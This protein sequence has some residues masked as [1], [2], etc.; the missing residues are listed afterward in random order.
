[1]RRRTLK[2]ASIAWIAAVAAGLAIAQLT[3]PPPSPA[4]LFPQGALV[5]AEARDL[6]Q[7]LQWWSGSEVKSNWMQTTNYT[8]F[9]N[10][11]LYQRLD[12]RLAEF[13]KG[14][15]AFTL[16]NLTEIAG[17]SSALALYD[18]GE[19][20]A[21][22]VTRV[23]FAEATASELWASRAHLR[24]KK[25]G[26]QYYYVEPDEGK[27]A[28][29]FAK[30]YLVI[31]SEEALLQDLLKAI[32]NPAAE[33]RLTQSDK[34]QQLA[35]G[36]PQSGGVFSLFL[37]QENLNT[38]RYFQN[39]WLHQNADELKAIQAAWIQLELQEGAIVEHRYFLRTDAPGGRPLQGADEY[40]KPFAAV[41]RE[42]L[43]L[44]APANVP[45]TAAALLR[46]FN[47][48]PRGE[49]PAG[50][51]PLYSASVERLSKAE[52]RSAYAEQIDEPILAPSADQLL[53]MDQMDTLQRILAEAQPSARLR[54]AYPLWDDHALFVQFPESIA[55]QFDHYEALN[56]QAFLDSTL[57]YFR[58][59]HSTQDP[60]SRWIQRGDGNYRLDSL[61]PVY[62]R[63]QAPWVV[64]STR[65]QEFQQ[66]VQALPPSATPPLVSY[67][68]FEF[69]TARWKYA[70]LM[71]RLDTGSFSG[72]SP[73]FF[74][75][76]LNSLVQVSEPVKRATL[77]RNENEEVIRYELK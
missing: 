24:R 21:A 20:R 7:L 47:R 44:S 29:A 63:F 36:R 43:I 70:R 64:V 53:H 13:G 33:G 30:P 52:A 39:Y 66:V 6:K 15:F 11:R 4:S 9:Q 48:L 25:V 62:V 72:D 5:Y 19:L 58:I 16:E 65:E 61:I 10:S 42:S 17:T 38:N 74:S 59:L 1:M 34:W 27:L 56:R 75:D 45:D 12:E 37:D 32:A 57:D 2:I 41:H 8:E 50:A 67:A 49:A 76:N 55:V 46:L 77:L 60:S 69:E 26:N 14:Q 68:E 40:L 18:I 3:E 73:L 71:K 35:A 28:F 31:A 23:G 22:A 51:P 54:F